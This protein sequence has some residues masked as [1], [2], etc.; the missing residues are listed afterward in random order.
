M[1]LHLAEID[2]RAACTN[3]YVITN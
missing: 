1:L 3:F 2:T